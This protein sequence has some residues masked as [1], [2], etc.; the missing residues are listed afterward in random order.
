MLHSDH[1]SYN[2]FDPA[3]S[4]LSL[5]HSGASPLVVSFNPSLSTLASFAIAPIFSTPVL[6]FSTQ[7]P[8]Y[9]LWAVF[10]SG[11]RLSEERSEKSSEL[12][13]LQIS[14]RTHLGQILHG[15]LS[16]SILSALQALFSSSG[17]CNHFGVFGPS[18][19]R[20]GRRL[21][22]TGFGPSRVHFPTSAPRTV[23]SIT[24]T[25]AA[26]W[27]PWLPAEPPPGFIPFS[28][29]KYMYASPSSSGLFL[30]M[31]VGLE[32]QHKERTFF[33]CFVSLHFVL[34]LVFV[35]YAST[36]STGSGPIERTLGEAQGLFTY[37]PTNH[38]SDD[39]WRCILFEQKTGGKEW[40]EG[41]IPGSL[42]VSACRLWFPVVGSFC[43]ASVSA[44]RA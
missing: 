36:E 23:W 22:T 16:P 30:W 20:R 3:T 26:R 42:T 11:N 31:P 38:F 25:K 28:L 37:T 14:V 4:C 7:F 24:S 9:V 2:S 32:Y 34:F 33:V 17:N 40:R 29:C 10:F 41:D 1:V 21:H 39:V 5:F 43:S 6:Y 8:H 18:K 44:V 15:E 13:A 35:D 19:R 27:I 12:S